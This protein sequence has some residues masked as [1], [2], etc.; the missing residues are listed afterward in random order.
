LE[1]DVLD[2]LI[3]RKGDVSQL[4]RFYRGWTG[5]GKFEQ[6]AEREIWL[7]FGWEWLN[8]PKSG[9]ILTQDEGGLFRRLLKMIFRLIPS[10]K[11]K[12]LVNQWN[13]SA[14]WA[15]VQIK[16]TS[17]HDNPGCYESTVKLKGT[18]TSK[19]NSGEDAP[20]TQV[21]QYDVERLVKL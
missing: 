2:S 5:L 12:L 19:L 18:V 10:G 13:D 11:L 20:L 15:K 1:A 21:N 16:Y 8:Y 3:Y 4:R 17:S 6:I 14:T 9:C 7:Q